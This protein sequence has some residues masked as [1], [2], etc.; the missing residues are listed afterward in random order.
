MFLKNYWYCAA[1]PHEIKNKPFRRIICNLPIVF[2]RDT[3]GRP[4]A[5][6]DRCSHRQAPL[7]T[8]KVRDD[9]IQCSYHGFVFNS[10]GKC[11]Y[12]PHQNK[13]SRRAHIHSYP[14][15][16][17]WGFIWIW[18]GDP[19]AADTENIPALP[20]T[21]SPKHRPVFL[22][23]HVKANHQLV[24]D[25]LLDISHAD[26]LH[27]DTLGSKSGVMDGPQPDKVEFRTWRE[28]DE[29]HSFRK[30]TNV[31]V[32]SFPKKWGSFS[33]NVNRTNIQMWEAPNTVHVHLEFENDENKIL[34]NHDH[35]MTPETETT[36]HY[37]M[38]FTRN[39]A[40]DGDTYPTD[41]DVYN[42]QY[43]VIN[44]D[45]IPMI[46]AQ[47]ANI[48]LCHGVTDVPVK[49]DK[50]ISDVH[51]HLA[52]LYRKQGINIPRNVLVKD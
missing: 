30:L 32:A 41:E 1:L 26:Y 6:E 14:I 22:Y 7:S 21:R 27:S 2:Y 43:S 16:E 38:D 12:I 3:K 19:D 28:G 37:F 23:Y 29:I 11:V 44:G 46:E 48:D 35:I 10:A 15:E 34:L 5:L 25:N 31:E 40:L 42:E 20:W 51:R 9:N 17:K 13:I 45:D 47:Q 36:T 18:S 52:V 24:A 39:F 50:L 49:A 8:G 4:V 33:R